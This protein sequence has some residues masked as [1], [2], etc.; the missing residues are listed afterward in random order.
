M[1]TSDISEMLDFLGIGDVEEL[2]KDIPERFR[3]KSL[4]IPPGLSEMEV[5]AYL[6]NLSSMNSRTARC[7]LGAGIYDVFIPSIVMEVLR[8]SELYTSYTPYQSEMSQGLLQLIFEYQS[9]MS[10]LTGMEVINASMYDGSSALGEGALMC[11]RIREGSYFLIPRAMAPWKKSVLRNYLQGTGTIVREY[12]FDPQTGKSDFNELLSSSKDACGVYVEMPGFFGL[13][14]EE[15]LDLKESLGNVPLV[16]GVNPSSL[17]T[18]VPPGDY[19]A[20]IVVGDGQSLGLGL[21]FG[22]PLLGI[23]GCRK[24]YV[25]K[26]PG[27]LVGL[28]TDSEGRRAFCL[29]LQARE[30]HIRRAKANSNICTNQTLLAIAAMVYIAAMGPEGM[31]EVA[32]RTEE[33]RASAVELLR[34]E[35]FHPRFSGPGYNEVVL[36]TERNPSEIFNELLRYSIIGGLP[37]NTM[38][39]E[40]GNSSLWAFNEVMQRAD[41]E[42]LMSVLEEIV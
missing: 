33:N 3:I 39:P 27:R 37:L 25:R 17:A 23:L 19:G 29:T 7:F 22:G 42:S 28:T 36:E 34:S 41:I 12:G 30:Q 18:T 15:I 13:Y 26:M 6:K 8:R 9:L 35:R 11:T 31:R 38:F 14:E 21:N 32:N 5:I 16:V 4:D 1:H 20:D 24:E 40:L 2:F 10:E